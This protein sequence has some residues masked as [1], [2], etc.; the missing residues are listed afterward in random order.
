[1]DK[2]KAQQISNGLN[3]FFLQ[4]DDLDENSIVVLETIFEVLYGKRK[5]ISLSGEKGQNEHEVG[6]DIP[7]STEDE[8]S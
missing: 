7:S 4:F 1:M 8:T 5:I 3:S 6:G 2:W